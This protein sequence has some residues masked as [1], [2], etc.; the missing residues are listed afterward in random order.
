MNRN[1]LKITLYLE[2]NKL[3]V[4]AKKFLKKKI[5][6]TDIVENQ[7]SVNF[8]VFFAV[9]SIIKKPWENVEN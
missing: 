5:N 8:L 2:N 9:F 6:K 3:E 1:I 7:I 4:F